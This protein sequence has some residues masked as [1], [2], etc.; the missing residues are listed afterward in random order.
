MSMIIRIL[1]SVMVLILMV[2]DLENNTI[3]KITEP[4]ILK[5]FGGN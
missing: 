1:Q 5:D 3:K 4:K 2:Y